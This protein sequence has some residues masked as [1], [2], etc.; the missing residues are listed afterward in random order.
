[1]YGDTIKVANKIITDKDLEE[2]F[3]NMYEEMES[4]EKQYKLELMQNE[5]YER[6]YQTWTV[7]NYEGSFKATVNFYDDTD[8]SFD[9][10]QNFMSIYNS[11]LDEIKNIYI[12]YSAYY[13]RKPQG[14]KEVYVSQN[15][16]MD[17][18][19]S[20][21]SISVNLN[22]EDKIMN[23]IFDVIKQKILAAPEKYDIVI[24]NKSSIKNK[25]YFAIGSIPTIVIL[26]L[27]FFVPVIRQIYAMTYIAYPLF[28][29]LLSFAIG[30]IFYGGKLSSL[31]K[32]I[33]PEQKYAGYD[34]TNAKRIYKDDIDKYVETSEILIGKNI[35][36]LKCRNE[37]KEIEKK[38]S[39]YIPI[40]L[41][42]ILVLSLVVVLTGN[43]F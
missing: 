30:N 9:N 14:Q 11:R 17:I 28:C 7:K 36:N 19:E 41:I 27:L 37:I 34:A 2:I 12:R 16:S 5:R 22:S 40:E 18:Y 25:I 31:Y 32:N 8:I 6:E 26:T 42:I 24:K 20:K 4:C 35:N 13:Y 1:M 10:F 23:Q 39:K 43:L 15:I 21:M 29:L 3:Y 38:Y 33:T